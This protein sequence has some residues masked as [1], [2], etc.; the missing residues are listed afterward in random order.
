[1]KVEVAPSGDCNK[2]HEHESRGS[3]AN[4]AV[5]VANAVQVPYHSKCLDYHFAALATKF[6]LQTKDFSYEGSIGMILY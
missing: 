2:R 1:M 5:D 6:L 3:M 4:G